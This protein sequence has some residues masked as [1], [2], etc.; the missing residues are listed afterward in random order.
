MVKKT[1]VIQNNAGIHV[2]PSGVI[3]DFVSD[4]DGKVTVGTENAK[5]ELNNIMSLLSLGLVKNDTVT[6]QVEGPDEEN[7]AQA[8]VELFERH[9]DFPKKNAEEN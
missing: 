9:F 4:Y 2:R 3:M 6:I 1:A 5:V 7:T 8:L